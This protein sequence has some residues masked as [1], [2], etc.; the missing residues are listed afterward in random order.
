MSREPDLSFLALLLLALAL[1]AAVRAVPGVFPPK[2]F[3]SYG[4]IGT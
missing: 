2:A 1:A 3:V 4:G